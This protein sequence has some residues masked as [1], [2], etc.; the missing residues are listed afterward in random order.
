MLEWTYTPPD[1]FEESIHIIRDRYEMTIENGKVEAK[2]IDLI[3]EENAEIWNQLHE[4]LNNRFLGVQ[5]L[6]HKIYELSKPSMCKIHPDGHKDFFLFIESSVIIHSADSVDL[7]VR[8][9]DGNIVGDTRRERIDKKRT[10]AELSER[11]QANPVV[12][13]ILH[14]YHMAVMEPDNELVHLYEIRDALATKFGG[15]FVAVKTLGISRTDW[16]KFGHLAN[17]APVKQGRH[18]GQHIGALRDATNE[19][20]SKAHEFAQKLILSFLE[21]IEH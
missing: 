1:Y 11:H 20:L 9:K 19:E 3:Y 6:T 21:Y 8:D 10:I 16:S 2:V 15:E 17:K 18:R 7:V 13:A 12:K 5:V 14:S 4:A